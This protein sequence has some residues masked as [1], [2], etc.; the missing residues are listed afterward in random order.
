MLQLMLWK[1]CATA[2]CASQS[3]ELCHSFVDI[4]VLQMYF[5]T[6]VVTLLGRSKPGTA[7][8]DL[9]MKSQSHKLILVS[10]NAAKV[11]KHTR[12]IQ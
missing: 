7:E 12:V 4:V 8:S 9:E 11:L 2:C 1:S 10:L 5:F 6:F 3:R